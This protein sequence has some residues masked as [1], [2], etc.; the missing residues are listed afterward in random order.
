MKIGLIGPTY[1]F[2][3]GIA[4]YTTLLCKTLR[5]QGHEVKF[6]SF[7]RQ[8]PNFLF[9]GKTDKDP[10]ESPVTVKDVDY[11]IDSLNPLSWLKAARELIRFRPHM[12][13]IPWWVAFWAPQFL[14][15][16]KLVKSCIPVE[17]VFL[18]H[19]VV[20]HEANVVKRL[21]SKM[22]LSTADRLV[23]HSAEESRKLRQLLGKR[24]T[25]VTAFHPTYA[26]LSDTAMTKDEAKRQLGL[27]GKVLLFFGFV[28]QYK[29]LDVALQ[30][31]PDVLAKQKAT[32]LVV[33][34]FWRNK[35]FYLNLIREL[36][37]GQS[38]RIVD[39]YIPNEE[40]GQY[41]AAA[42]LVIQ[43]YHSA[44]GSGIC[45]IA[46]GLG[47]PVIATSVG[48][49]PEVVKDRI[50]GRLVPP[51]DA[52][53]L[54]DAI[55]ES[56]QT[57]VLQGLTENAANTKQKFSWEKMAEILC[58]QQSHKPNLLRSRSL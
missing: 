11:I 15:I 16:A 22:V 9:P 20:E 44:S 45:Q 31:M 23:T 54:A 52:K 4:H 13:I 32:L 56:L 58:S 5:Q 1:P 17:L 3:G 24:V 6:I 40:V 50:N 37:I 51:G 30:A 10:S 48:S 43:P 46:F 26:E 53:T 33:G 27:S 38:V 21:A 34:E 55:V 7:V 14:T 2:R 8:Y 42:D 57:E 36:D 25:V 47:R 28:R 18:C 12:V 19:N 49:L 35:E 41:F 39:E 29:G